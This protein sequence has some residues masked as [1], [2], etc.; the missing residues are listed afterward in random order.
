[1]PKGIPAP[2][3]KRELSKLD[4]TSTLAFKTIVDE[5]YNRTTVSGF[6]SDYV[7][8]YA[9]AG[10]KKAVAAA[11]WATEWIKSKISKGGEAPAEGEQVHAPAKAEVVQAAGEELKDDKSYM[12]LYNEFNKLC[13][14]ISRH[15]NDANSPEELEGEEFKKFVNGE[16]IKLIALCDGYVR[17][18]IDERSEFAK[19]K[20]AIITVI[21]DWL[22]AQKR[23]LAI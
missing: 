21:Q 20:K 14:E 4:Y 2:Q 7:S 10:A 19:E 6:A 23:A 9:S 16:L 3:L 1:M 17:K 13:A 15:I 18:P 22:E 8:Y 12:H 11:S 5:L